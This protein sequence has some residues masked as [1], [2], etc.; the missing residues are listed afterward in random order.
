M[1]IIMESDK[2][3]KDSYLA[4]NSNVKDRSSALP[5]GKLN[6]LIAA[7]YMVT[8]VMDKDEPLREKL[9]GLGSSLI[10]DIHSREINV[11]AKISEILSFLDIAST[12]GMISVMNAGILKKEFSLFQASLN[13]LY[14]RDNPNWL[15]DLVANTSDMEFQT[16]TPTRTETK[17]YHGQGTRLGV[18][19]GST[20]MKALS[21]K[22][23]QHSEIASVKENQKDNFDILRNQR[24]NE[25][26]KIISEKKE[27][28]ISD[29]RNRAQELSTTG[30]S[31]LVSCSEKTLQRELI[32][33]L[34]DNILK[35]TGEKRWSKY[36]IS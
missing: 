7:L 33:M 28:T 34:K 16:Y 35:K 18:Q 5:V 6:K 17:S 27:A 31:V 21:D 20:L 9:R 15:S 25:I 10:S 23:S 3:L 1:D 13:T 8:D 24:R 29:I 12:V 19:K 11:G 36:F 14:G 30:E 4:T 2:N 26:I 32:S 22:I